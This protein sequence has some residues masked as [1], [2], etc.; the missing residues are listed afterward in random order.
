MR[1]TTRSILFAV[2]AGAAAGCGDIPK[3]DVS[4]QFTDKNVEAATRQLMFVVREVAKSGNPCDPLWGTNRP[5]LAERAWLVGYPNANDL[6]AAPIA[7]GSYTLFVYSYAATLDK[8]CSSDA[9]CAASTIGPRCRD[10]G[11][12]EKACLADGTTVKPIS[13]GCTAANVDVPTSDAPTVIPMKR[14]GST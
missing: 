4:L 13:G 8:N 14:P 12:F 10:I 11:G 9:D 6:V 5:N 3:L 2:L 1:R 7:P